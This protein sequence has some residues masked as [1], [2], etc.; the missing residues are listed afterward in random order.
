MEWEVVERELGHCGFV[1]HAD[2][3]AEVVLGA[4]EGW[5]AGL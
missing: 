4:A 5:E 3:V 1:A 2:V